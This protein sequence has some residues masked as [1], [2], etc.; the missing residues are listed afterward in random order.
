MS[1]AKDS[2][3]YNLCNPDQDKMR[4]NSVT[5]MTLLSHSRTSGT[6]PH[7]TITLG[8]LLKISLEPAKFAVSWMMTSN[9]A[10]NSY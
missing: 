5:K 1:E 2:T 10:S 8:F 3:E 7:L 6:Y 9:P 4:R